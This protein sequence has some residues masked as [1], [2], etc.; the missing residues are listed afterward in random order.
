MSAATATRRPTTPT[1]STTTSSPT[2]SS[3]PRPSPAL[4][5]APAVAY[6]P[7]PAREGIVATAVAAGAAVVVAM[8]WTATAGS[9]LH[10]VA[11]VLT[12]AGR[13]TGLLGAYLVL[14]EVLLMARV[15]WLDSLIG[16]DR[17][18]VWHRRNGEYSISLL[19]AHALL[20]LWGYGLTD[21]T[22]VVHEART[23]LTYPYMIATSLG[24][25][26]LVAIGALSA[27]AAR[28]RLGYQVW[29]VLHLGTYVAIAAS[30]SHQ[31]NSGA[32]FIGHPLNRALWV[33]MYAFVATVVL[34]Y[35]VGVPI[36][37]AY[38]HQ[39]RVAKVVREGPGVVSIHVAGRRLGELECE[40][41]QFFYWRFLTPGGWWQAHPF[42]L[43]APP[44]DTRLR[45]T[46][47]SLGDHTH[48]LQRLK[49]GTRVFAEGPYGAFTSRR[50]TR[51]RV[52][53]IGGGVGIAPLRALFESLPA[54]P[55]DLTLLYRA[56]RVEDLVFRDELDRIARQ[57]GAA[58]HYLV[59]PRTMRPDPLAAATLRR[60]IPDLADHDV[61][62][63][64]P[65]GLT[66]TV[67]EN[68][69][70]AGVPRRRI[71]SEGFEL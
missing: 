14:V 46:V 53:L 50:R 60:N 4:P 41:G 56:S 49:P 11:A 24:L 70:V 5:G 27:R 21:H 44:T 18:A 59:G 52:L 36:R 67:V 63:C 2:T 10:G 61:Y 32:D 20:I 30:F 16:L 55:G 37:D 45:L 35:R 1:T 23:I 22:N 26:G 39:L 17:L 57:R 66:G 28:R 64:G 68:L 6:V 34:G 13:I 62:V 25:L 15:P 38:R 42:S 47:K 8:W 58:V 71:H 19:V 43:S 33:A 3:A 29:Y 51:R 54:A 48:Q 12:A 7:Q 9:S 31:L 65:P 69:A 40:P